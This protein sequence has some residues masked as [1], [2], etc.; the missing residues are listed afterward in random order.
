MFGDRFA[1][2][3]NRQ[4]FGM[5]ARFGMRSRIDV[6]A[7]A[8][9]RLSLHQTKL[10]QQGRYDELSD[11]YRRMQFDTVYRRGRTRVTVRMVADGPHARMLLRLMGLETGP[12]LPG[13][14]EPPREYVAFWRESIQ[15]SG[16]LEWVDWD[17]ALLE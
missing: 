1:M 4:F 6:M 3:E 12:S 11:L 17:Q 2:S 13:Q 7:N 14:A 10:T 16:V 8:A 15:N 5:G 9:P